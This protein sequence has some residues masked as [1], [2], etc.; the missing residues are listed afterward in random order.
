M[1]RMIESQ[2]LSIIIRPAQVTPFAGAIGCPG[3]G[4]DI[5]KN[6]KWFTWSS[7]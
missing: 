6:N 1:L 3:S 4:G 7:L 2:R 5:A